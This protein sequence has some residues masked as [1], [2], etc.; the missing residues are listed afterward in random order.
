MRDI[1]RETKREVSIKELR[2]RYVTGDIDEMSP[3]M[4]LRELTMYFEC[5]K[6]NPS[7]RL[8][9]LR[10]SLVGSASGWFAIKGKHL[11]SY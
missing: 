6:V 1:L 5:I 9:L 10:K 2:N 7:Q 8:D 4:Y 11:R 3:T